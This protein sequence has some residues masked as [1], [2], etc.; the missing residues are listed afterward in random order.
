MKLI[1]IIWVKIKI[2]IITIRNQSRWKNNIKD[3]IK[4]KDNDYYDIMIKNDIN[5]VLCLQIK[6]VE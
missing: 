6:W 5:Q 2:I 4:N 1:I 3:N